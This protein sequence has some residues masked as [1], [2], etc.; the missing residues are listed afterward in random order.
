[1]CRVV[2]CVVAFLLLAD[3][4]ED[5]QARVAE[6]RRSAIMET[7]TEISAAEKEMKQAQ[8]SRQKEKVEELKEKI[9][10]LRKKSNQLKQATAEELVPAMQQAERAAKAAEFQKLQEKD[11]DRQIVAAGPVSI[12]RMGIVTNVIGLPELVVQVQNN[13]DHTIEAV[14]IEADC[15]NKFD[16]PVNAIGGDNRYKCHYKYEIEPRG[17]AVIKS[18]MSLQ[19][20]TAKA[21]V[22]ISRVRI[23]DGEVWTQTKEKAKGT[24][25]GMA[26]AR[27]AE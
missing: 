1:M 6:Y 25:Y 18:Q 15:F 21:D 5:E 11:R 13:T 22:W 9:S 8:R 17:T 24:P 4:S 23:G 7:A 19:R 2:A 27:L 16:E 14:E 10:A 20:L 12:L 26:R 3:L